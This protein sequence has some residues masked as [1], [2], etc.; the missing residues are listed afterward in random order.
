VAPALLVEPE[1][2]EPAA[3]AEEIP[4]SDPPE[5][6][7]PAADEHGDLLADEGADSCPVGESPDP[8]FDSVTGDP[9][10]A[11][12]ENIPV[13]PELMTAITTRLSLYA[14]LL[15]L[16]EERKLLRLS[17][18]LP[19][20]VREELARQDAEM[21]NLP[22]AAEAARLASDL[23][24]RREQEAADWGDARTDALQAAEK[25][26]FSQWTL[27]GN[28]NL[29]ALP[30]VYKEAYRLA[31]DEPLAVELTR[32][33][34]AHGR[35]LGGAVY[36]LALELLSLSAS[37]E[38][39]RVSTRIH[40]LADEGSGGLL[41]RLGKLAC[42]LRDR[43]EIQERAE[44]LERERRSHAHRAE[45]AQREMRFITRTLVR[46]FQDVYAAAARHYIPR[47]GDMPVAVR[48][49]LR[50]GA[51]GFK[52]W[53]MR[54]ELKNFIQ[55][56]CAHNVVTGMDRS[57]D[58]LNILYADEYL[59][60]VAGMECSPS[61][62]ESLAALGK[63]SDAAKTDRAYRRIVNARTYNELMQ[64][65]LADLDIR[66]QLFDSETAVIED[67]LAAARAAPPG[68]RE[69]IFDLE[70]EH[71]NIAIRKSNLEKQIKRIEKE[72]V[73]SII[74]S[75]QEAEGRF[76][77]GELAMPSAE[78]LVGREVDA[79]FAQC[80]RMGDGR[81]MPMVLRTGFPLDKDIVNIRGAVRMKMVNLELLDPGLFVNV[82][83][84]AKKRNNRVELR[85]GPIVTI[86]PV[87]SQRGL[88]IM[89][90]EGM[91]GGHLALPLCFIKEDLQ[92]RRLLQMLADF[93]WETSCAAVGRDLINSDTLAGAFMRTRWEWRNHPKARRE[94]GL[95]FNE[96]NDPSNWRRVYEVYLPDAMT[97]GKQLFL[98]NPDFYNAI[99]GH[100]I[101]LPAGV[102]LLRR[103]PMSP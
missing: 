90:R 3:D 53:W 61:P 48:A 17:G 29:E 4:L 60:A 27:I 92:D 82:I 65:M 76:R 71:Q 52:P 47:S 94:K 89:G 77:K 21:E 22:T 9:A 98:R 87:A 43:A 83:I 80:R 34:I 19:E 26:A 55:D 15:D 33:K 62:D 50:Y 41:S 11:G 58:E 39:S 44:Q 49:F 24:A 56:D 46:E 35:L 45:L 101:D 67:R 32:D 57:R 100:Y 74:D 5:E 81:F 85:V 70:T 63:N 96:L 18:N 12:L 25:M 51:I 42:S 38:R 103:S 69:N 16:A 66:R 84:P 93:R 75:V 13:S 95:I 78:F 91:E 20:D 73:S 59:A 6:A 1:E 40:R 2:P 10:V 99:I 14:L 54:E 7:P 86:L 88:C 97:G 37:R 23:R 31:A 8:G 30:A 64:K 79:I 36:L 28:S 68:K 102:P 72:V